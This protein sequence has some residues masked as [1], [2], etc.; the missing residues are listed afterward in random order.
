MNPGQIQEQKDQNLD[1]LK[2]IYW[3]ASRNKGDIRGGIL[4]EIGETLTRAGIRATLDPSVRTY[5]VHNPQRSVMQDWTWNLTY[6]QQS[7]LIAAVRGPDGIKKDHVVKVLMRWMRRCILISAFDRC[8]IWDPHTPGG[9]SF[10]GPLKDGDIHNYIEIYLRHVDEL[11]H[12]FQLHFMHASEI[13]GYK[14]PDVAIREFWKSMYL[15]IVKDAHL[16]PESE[17]TMD[18]R[19]GD[20]EENWR[21]AET[22]TAK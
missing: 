2:R 1:L 20:N 7:V 16:C 4:S 17:E 14:H 3:T 12:H 6:M 9:G 11:P 22:V 21:N 19:L 10:T 8:A 15:A 5:P 13:L 18:K